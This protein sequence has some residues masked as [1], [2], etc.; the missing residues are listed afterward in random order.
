[1]NEEVP[2][3]KPLGIMIAFKLNPDISPSQRTQFYRRLTGYI[4]FSNY[5]KFRYRR[6]GLLDEIPHINPIKSLMII[7]Q[8]HED[9]VLSF[10]RTEGAVVYA[11]KMLLEKEDLE[12][13]SEKPEKD[14]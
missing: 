14:D 5:G 8:E 3:K 2:P 9:K 7:A 12:D 10:L 6:P 11:R 1:M 13:L 4:D